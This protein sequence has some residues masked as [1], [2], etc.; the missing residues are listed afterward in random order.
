[1]QELIGRYKFNGIRRLS[2]LFAGLVNLE[3]KH[4]DKDET[5][6]VPV[7][8]SRRSLKQRGWDHMQLVGRRLSVYYGYRVADLLNRPG[9][10]GMQKAGSRSDRMAFRE[11]G[12]RV[13]RSAERTAGGRQII[14]IDDI[15]TTGSTIRSA[16]SAL[17]DF[18]PKEIMALV[19]AMD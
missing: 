13:K 7:P 9:G 6:L 16:A 2:Y 15:M 1:M 4:L 10:R 17:Q 14:V 5:V 18:T 19:L 8:C 12:Y 11:V 3:L